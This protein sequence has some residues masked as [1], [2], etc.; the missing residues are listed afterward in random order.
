MTTAGLGTILSVWAHPDD[1]TYL[2]A[3]VMAEAADLGQ[4]VVCV[5]ATAGEHGTSDPQTWPPARLG[6][7]APLGGGRS[8][9]RARRQ[10]PP[11]PRAPRR[12]PRRARGGRAALAIGR[13]LD[14]VEPDTILTFGPD[15][16]TFHPDHIAVSRWVTEAWE[17]RGRRG[18]LLY[19]ASTVE[20]LA[21]FGE[22]YEQ[23][24]TYM[25]DERPVGRARRR[26]RRPRRADGC[27]ARPQA[28]R[29]RGDGVADRRRDGVNWVRRPT[30]RWWRR[31][32]SSTR[33]DFKTWQPEQRE[34]AVGVEERV[35]ARRPC[36][37]RSRAPSAP[38]ARSPPPAARPVLAERR[39]AVGLDRHQPRPAAA[40]A[41]P[42]IQPAMSS[43]PCSHS[44]YGGI[45]MRRVLVQQRRQRVHV[46]AL[47]RVDVA[48]EE[49]SL[50]VVDRDASTSAVVEV[51][52]GERGP[53]PLQRAVDRG[54]RGVEQLGDLRRP[55]SAA[56][57]AGSARR[58]GGAAG[59]AGR[60]RTPGG[61]TRGPRRPRRDRRR[62]AARGRRGPARSRSPRRA[63]GRA[64]PARRP[65]GRRGPSGGRA[66]GLPVEHVEADVGG[67]A[68]QPRAQ[69][70]AALE[71]VVGAPGPRPSSPATASSASNAEPSIR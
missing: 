65:A 38:T 22:L 48:G 30:R 57:R 5:S 54:D 15:G 28:H 69:R 2:A 41:R 10:R 23:W 49:R 31:K 13:L 35:D 53:G 66:A 45:D 20:H 43:R 27:A 11:L 9:G 46:V 59:A 37:R 42:S 67:D 14:E 34:Q 44:S 29:P 1:E 55:A 24:G 7:R 51:G 50:L 64:S 25:T 3:G 68:V 18:R 33:P 40:V 26:A 8:D 39:R 56:P 52:V 58:A 16:I 21:H 6:Q 47:E 36:R 71:A 61:S 60:R 17:R 4:R 62:R 63:P 70:R 12:R 19:A 32:P